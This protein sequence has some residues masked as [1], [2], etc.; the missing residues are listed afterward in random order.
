VPCPS[1]TA[2]RPHAATERIFPRALLQGLG[3]RYEG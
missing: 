1:A 3:R 2:L